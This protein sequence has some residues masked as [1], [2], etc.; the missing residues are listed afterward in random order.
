MT[1][2]IPGSYLD[3]LIITRIPVL[4]GQGLPLFGPL[5]ADLPLLHVETRV[6]APSGFVQSTYRRL[7]G[8]PGSG[9]TDGVTADVLER[10]G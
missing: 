2:P 6:F 9:T 5:D 10:E 7:P 8:K 4:L 3:E 1:Y